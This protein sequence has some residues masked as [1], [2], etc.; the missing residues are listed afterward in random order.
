MFPASSPAVRTRWR[1]WLAGIGVSLAVAAVY[2][3]S[4]G[5]PFLFD[6]LGAVVRNESIRSVSSVLTPPAQTTVSGRPVANATLALNRAMSGEAVWSYHATNLAIHVAAALVLFGL[7]RRTLKL[8]SWNGNYEGM[9]LPL[10]VA[11]AA[12]WALHPLQT[13]SVTYV[14]QRVES[15]MGCFYLL[16]LYAFVRSVQAGRPAGWKIISVAACALG[17]GTKEVMVSAPLLVLLYDRF[18]VA[19]SFRESWRCR[20][21]YYGSLAATWLL[22]AWLVAGT[23]GRS[24]TAGFGAEISAADY[25]LT[26]CHAVL[27]YLRLVFWPAPLIFDYGVWT[28]SGFAAVW[29]QTVL[30]I[31]LGAATL[32]GLWRRRAWSFPG[33]WFFATLAP[34]SSIVPVASQTM[35]E[36]RVYLALAAPVLLV[37][38][39]L[40]NVAGARRM[41]WICVVLAIGLGALTARRNADYRTPETIWADTVEKRPANPRAHQNLASAWI[42]AGRWQDALAASERAFA[43]GA[44]P[45]GNVHNLIGRSLVGLGRPAE[46]LRFHEEALARNPGDFETLNARGMALAA[47]GR[48]E[49]AIESYE[50]A[51]RLNSAH[52]EAHNNLANALAGV[53]RIS[54]ALLHYEN[55]VQLRPDFLE[56]RA[57]WGRALAE[58]GRPAEAIAQYESLIRIRADAESHADLATALAE[59]GRIAEA[60]RHYET[61]LEFAPDAVET[62]IRFGNLLLATG[63]ANGAQ[64]QFEAVLKARPDHAEA[65]Y[66]LANTLAARER[67]AEAIQHYEAALRAQPELTGA[68]HNLAVVL[69]QVGRPAEA[70]P[71]FQD[72]LRAVPDASDVHHAL[73]LA[74]AQLGRWREAETHEENA[75]RLQPDFVEAREHLE[76]LRQQ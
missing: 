55:A 29:W 26:Q 30:L 1:I 13:E 9:A 11:V 12:L 20:R 46:A 48:P 3:N 54:E 35:A 24:G 28:V 34:S 51:L 27:H 62:R 60:V 10:A 38:F 18:F 49:E 32:W 16:T 23:G 53:G 41:F 15:L 73:A 31:A 45:K 63:D 72:V 25:F 14:V 68:R 56:A 69:L 76:W 37:V 2:L 70:I 44:D 22:L 5:V 57:N 50:Q 6:D 19:G 4:L 67:F 36:H 39:T 75:L 65:H 33:A 74:L 42:E 7:V 59:A 43:L 21:L 52:A 17:M 58:A 8:P 47:A 40:A 66:N 64:A 61:A 71:H